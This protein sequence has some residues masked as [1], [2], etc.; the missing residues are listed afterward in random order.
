MA[1]VGEIMRGMSCGLNEI[2]Y[3]VVNST[4]AIFL[5]S[6]LCSD[7]QLGLEFSLEL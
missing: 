3:G 6:G 7:E 5:L 1:H 4:D 2:Y